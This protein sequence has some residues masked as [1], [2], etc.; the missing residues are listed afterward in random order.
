[1]SKTC[2]IK[3]RQLIDIFVQHYS[4]TL[5]MDS[6]PILKTILSFI[7]NSRNFKFANVWVSIPILGRFIRIF[8]YLIYKE[9]Y[10][11][12][13]SYRILCNL[14]PAWSKKNIEETC[15]LFAF[16]FCHINQQNWSGFGVNIFCFVL[17]LFYDLIFLV[18]RL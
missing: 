13:A 17:G 9:L 7:N 8:A 6:T 12:T 1:M 4:H 3:Q 18:F 11:Q 5:Y 15:F 16:Y 10:R 14:S 2:S